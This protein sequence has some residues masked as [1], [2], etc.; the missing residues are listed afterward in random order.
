MKKFLIALTLGVVCGFLALS[1][2]ER[3]QAKPMRDILPLPSVVYD[4]NGN[5]V[6]TESL[7][8]KVVALYFSAQWCIPCKQFTP[9][10]TDFRNRQLD[11]DFEVVFMS[12]DHSE[13]HKSDYMKQEGM[14]WLNAPGHS[15]DE[16]KQIMDFYDLPG[17][18][19]LVVFGPNGEL[20]TTNGRDE[21][22]RN[23]DQA[24]TLWRSRLTTAP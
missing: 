18:P 12:L 9:I 22:A 20:I 15:S 1:F 7:R 3:V 2:S 17:V 16:I 14:Q 24:L 6:P 21:V 23:P 5:P 13:Q 11:K 8:G 4:A 19:S 10:L